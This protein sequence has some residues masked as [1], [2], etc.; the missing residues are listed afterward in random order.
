MRIPSLTDNAWTRYGVFALLYAAQ[1]IPEG[2]ILLAV[3]AY[4]AAQGVSA[5]AIAGVIGVAGLPWALKL[6]YGPVMDRWSFL[7]MGRRRPWVLFGQAGLT[8]SFASL[9]LIGDPA[10]NVGMITAGFFVVSFFGAFQDVGTDGMAIDV[11]PIEQ[12]ARA[13]GVMWGAKVVGTAGAGA[14][15][16]VLINTVGFAAATLTLAALVAAI[17]TVVVL[18]RERPGER[19]LP[20]TPGEASPAAEE[21]QLDGWRDIVT[22]LWRAFV[23]PA[24][25]VVAVLG[26]VY[27]LTRGFTMALFPVFTVQELGWADTEFSQVMAAAGLVG[28]VVG[29]AIGGVLTDRIGKRRAL[30]GFLIALAL[31]HGAMAVWM[32]SGLAAQTMTAYIY[33]AILFETLATIAFFAI[34]MALCWERV[35]A[36]QFG[37]YMAILN[38]GM[39]A[40]SALF[41]FLSTRFDYGAMFLVLGGLA[42]VPAL[43]L[44][45]VRVEQHRDRLATL[46]RAHLS[47]VPDV[48]P[49]PSRSP[50]V[51]E[52]AETF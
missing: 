15:G 42:L 21:A 35:S 4:L 23:L 3:P 28:G 32:F 40:G 31:V 25:L 12:Q 29:M 26:F 9:A 24:S 1:G 49:E 14:V 22:S 39:S 50:A 13:N 27:N 46:D 52:P 48:P 38:F 19:A 37:L 44:P 18:V 20:W 16:S 11:V 33:G 7:P 30:G 17:M 10:A 5:A 36:T 43:L 34:A 2:M 47:E 6:F 45:L 8:L 41:G 51:L